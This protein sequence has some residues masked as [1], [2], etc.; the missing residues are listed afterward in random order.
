YGK[1]EI[2]MAITPE[3]AGGVATIGIA[4]NVIPHLVAASPGLKRMIDLP[5]PGALM[6]PSAYSRLT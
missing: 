6:G 5:V 4:V 2:H 3:I 1:P